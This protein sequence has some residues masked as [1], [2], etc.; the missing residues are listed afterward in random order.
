MK[1]F[2]I[3]IGILP[4]LGV[5]FGSV[6]LIL[7]LILHYR[8]KQDLLRQGQYTPYS[9]QSFRRL[10]LLVGMLAVGTGIP[11]SALFFVA[12]GLHFPLLGGLIPT[13]VGL[14]L[15]FYYLF[16]QEEKK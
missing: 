11:L 1:V 3:L 2:P 4:I 14:A 7:F 13:S 8:F 10:L 12:Y 16:T 5:I 15:I 6:H 9:L